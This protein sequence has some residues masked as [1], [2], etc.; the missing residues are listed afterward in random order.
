ME[1]TKKGLF[2]KPLCKRQHEGLK[3]NKAMVSKRTL[4]MQGGKILVAWF[5]SSND[6]DQTSAFVDSVMKLN[7]TSPTKRLLHIALIKWVG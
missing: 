7:A 2:G 3:Q 5:Y 4:K 1:N 6:T